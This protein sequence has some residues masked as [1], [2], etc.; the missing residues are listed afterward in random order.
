M[1]VLVAMEQLMLLHGMP[2]FKESLYFGVPNSDFRTAHHQCCVTKWQ[3]DWDH[4][5]NKMSWEV[6]PAVYSWPSR[7]S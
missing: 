5:Q 4:T 7:L 3:S 6:K 2:R 1:W